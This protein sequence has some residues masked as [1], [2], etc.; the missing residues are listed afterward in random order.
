MTIQQDPE[1]R[2]AQAQPGPNYSSYS[3]EEWPVRQ[4]DDHPERAPVYVGRDINGTDWWTSRDT[5]DKAMAWGRREILHNQ[6]P[7]SPE[8]REEYEELWRAHYRGE[9]E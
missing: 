3:Y 7:Y 2:Q 5:S 8:E 1:E 4:P 9:C 6:K